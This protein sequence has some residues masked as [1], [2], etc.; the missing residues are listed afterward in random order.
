MSN[1]TTSEQS[2]DAKQARIDRAI[3]KAWE[4]ARAGNLPTLLRQ[5][6]TG[7]D[8]KQVWSVGSRTAGGTVYTIDLAADADGISTLCDCAGSEADRIC[9]HRAA[10]RLAALGELDYHDARRRVPVFSKADIFGRP[11]PWAPALDE[12]SA[13]AAAV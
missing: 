4:Q 13:Y 10:T 7:H 9:W 12:A 6:D 8:T 3:A 5:H 2:R 11:D 1:A